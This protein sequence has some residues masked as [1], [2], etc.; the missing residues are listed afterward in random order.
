MQFF[1]FARTSGPVLTFKNLC[2][3]SSGKGLNWVL[4]KVEPFGSGPIA[5]FQIQEPLDQFLNRFQFDLYVAHSSMLK[6]MQV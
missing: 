5:F 3:G 2:G 4:P 6:I 1:L